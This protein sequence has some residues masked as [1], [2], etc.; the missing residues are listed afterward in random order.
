[1]KTGLFRQAFGAAMAVLTG[2]FV[3]DAAAA[4]VSF[5]GATKGSWFEP[6]NWSGGAVPTAADD[7]TIS[8]KEVVAEGDI[9]AGSISLASGANLKLGSKDLRPN[10]TATI[11][12]DFT[13]D[14]A[15]KVYVYAGELADPS[16]FYTA[17]Q[18]DAQ[19][20]AAIAALWQYRNKVIVGG[21][22]E[23]K[24]N[25]TVYPDSP[26][27]TAVPVVFECG[28]FE[29]AE[30][31]SF[32]SRGR[33]FD[34]I[35][36]L[37]SDA[38][39]GAK[40][41][42]MNSN[43]TFSDYGWTWAFGAGCG[44]NTG[45]GYG[46][47]S[48]SKKS[49]TKSG[50]T[51]TYGYAY[52]NS[53]APFLSG[54]PCGLYQVINRPDYWASNPDSAR[55]SG[56]IVIYSTGAMT[57]N[58]EMNAS[59]RIDTYVIGNGS[60]YAAA[61]GG[62]IWLVTAESAITFGANALL[63]ARGGKSSN[64][65]SY[66]S[67]GPG[68]R[69]AVAVNV[70]KAQMD[71]LAAG[72]LPAGYLESSLIGGVTA[73]VSSHGG[74][75]DYVGTLSYVSNKKPIPVHVTG[76]GSVRCGDTV[77]T[78]D[79]TVDLAI[80][81]TVTLEA[82]DTAYGAFVYWVTNGVNDVS[83]TI[84]VG[85]GLDEV[86]AGFRSSRAV[87]RTWNGSVSTAWENP[88]N[89]TPSGIPGPNDDLIVSGVTS[90]TMEILTGSFRAHDLVVGANATVK[91]GSKADRTV[92]IA[93]EL[94]GDFVVTNGGKFYAYGP[95]LVDVS[96]YETAESDYYATL[97]PALWTAAK[98]L[99]IGGDFT[100]A[101]NSS[102]YVDTDSVTGLPQI[103]LVGGDFTVAEGGLVS[104]KDRGWS[105]VV[106]PT[107]EAIA[108]YK[109]SRTNGAWHN[110]FLWTLAPGA[111]DDYY[112]GAGYGGHG[113]L[114]SSPDA[115]R[116]E[117]GHYYSNPYGYAF[118]PF[119]AGSPSGI[120]SSGYASWTDAEKTR[121]GGQVTVFAKGTAAIAGRVDA[122]TDHY[123]FAGASGGGIWIA[124]D[125][126][127]F[128]DTA[129][130]DVHGGDTYNVGSYKAGSGG[131][132]AFTECTNDVQLATMAG[133]ALP[134]G[135]LDLGTVEG[136]VV[137]LACGIQHTKGGDHN[138]D[139]S[140][141]GTLAY[142]KE[143][144]AVLHVAIDGG[145]SIACGGDV[146]TTNFTLR[147]LAGTQIVLTATADPGRFNNWD[148][149]ILAE[150]NRYSASLTLDNFR[151]PEATITAVMP[152]GHFR[153]VWTGAA[154]DGDLA[155]KAN[156][157]PS[158][159]EIGES[160]DLVFSNR[161]VTLSKAF[162]AGG[163]ILEGSS[164]LT[165]SPVA[166]EGECTPAALYAGATAIRLPYGLYLRGTSKLVVNCDPVTGTA[167]KFEV[168]DFELAKGAKIDAKAKGWYWFE[169]TDDPRARFTVAA[170]NRQ[171]IALGAGYDYYIGGG[172]GANGGGANATY[173]L[174]YGFAAA[175]FL[176][177]SPNGMYN[178]KFD[179]AKRGGGV[180][181]IHCTGTARVDGTIDAD[182]ENV[183][184]GVTSYGTA[185][186]GSIWITAANYIGGYG[187]VLR[188]QSGDVPTQSYTSLG[189]GGR[190]AIGVG[191]TAAEIDA[192]AAGSEVSD[193]TVTD[194]IYSSDVSVMTGYS[195]HNAAS[196]EFY[197]GTPGTAVTVAG[198]S[199]TVLAV[200]SDGVKATGV[201]PM[202]GVYSYDGALPAFEA[203]EYGYDPGNPAIR[204]VSAGYELSDSAPYTLVWKWGQKQY[205][206]KVNGETTWVD[207]DAEHTVSFTP[208]A[209][210]EFIVWRGTLPKDCSDLATFTA[211][212]VAPIEIEAVTKPQS[213]G[214]TYTWSGVG[215]WY[216][217]SMWSPNGIPG[218]NDDVVIDGGT[219]TVTA[220]VRCKSLTLS[221]G[222]VNVGYENWL[223]NA[224]LTVVG[225]LEVP[226]GKLIVYGG[227][228]S[229]FGSLADGGAWVKVGG[230]LT[231]SGTS[232]VW[233]YSQYH[234]G[235]SPV[236]TAAS[237]SVASTAKFDAT[238][239]G[240]QWRDA[241]D[242]PVENGYGWHYGRGGGYG[243]RGGASGTANQYWGYAY[244][245][246]FAPIHP[247]SPNGVYNDGYDHIKRGGGLVRIHVTGT[248]TV[249]GK[250]LAE[251]EGQASGNVFGGASGGGIWITANAFAFGSGA[252]LSVKG[253]PATYASVGGGGRIAL[254]YNQRPEN[255]AALAETGF[256]FGHRRMFPS[257]VKN[258]AEF[259]EL[260]P[261]VTVNV[262]SGDQHNTSGAKTG[263]PYSDSA[264]TFAYVDCGSLPGGTMFLIR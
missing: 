29:L 86:S 15:S 85:S 149:D 147:V 19:R 43:T 148:G 115:R 171:T 208:A 53:F 183:A 236:F 155:N 66:G 250:I 67:D 78:E 5:T 35:N 71:T 193:V 34:Y 188:A 204:Y 23:V 249:D 264:G 84:T 60:E 27:K 122:S 143:Q 69:I 76:D 153:R 22:L 259:A 133:G 134:L 202:Y 219:C 138:P 215:N 11:T 91:L 128:G 108:G 55:G 72:S 48:S 261:G 62:S 136:A 216:E 170:V 87:V 194:G 228:A 98:R 120:T 210:D 172:H 117:G 209:G 118:A 205:R 252:E 12:G 24:G 245:Q 248:A 81:E 113:Y 157:N 9:V 191:L 167:P 6:T 93:F 213:A 40:P 114:A 129:V 218:A 96:V 162:T 36:E 52:G 7:V 59:S 107:S 260:F 154:G 221:A 64:Y 175:P 2:V 169:G 159:F 46:A 212:V 144:E 166:I 263:G 206:V 92:D 237:L 150:G 224:T 186:G 156:Y 102:V 200:E 223:T 77:Y 152:T 105:W 30:G 168:G 178:K 119:L 254:G 161:S 109:T 132:V 56:A 101:T 185:S 241:H 14:G 160:D 176:P 174:A 240:M 243:G 42:S 179:N 207:A 111:G 82:V 231:L 4:D 257:C 139:L 187:S 47:S 141:S 255:I 90:T 164:T 220:N 137:N 192:L 126:F 100:V 230:A 196:G 10:I 130:F 83:A 189:A 37:Y 88:S 8:G 234:D 61:T 181:R 229:G 140:E 38:P 195:L 251:G 18:G 103:F 63:R 244:G 20:D 110:N 106:G 238:A 21:R 17:Y 226:N 32:N 180:V 54:S 70:S 227:P 197:H 75:L 97:I 58:G 94:S 201:E 41:N 145:G 26:K 173:G 239:K 232:E 73:D 256:L 3:N 13:V 68:G 25:S 89:W 258:A 116:Y 45:A 222:R 217:A 203:P 121:G 235:G 39:A 104:A 233:P 142:V 262:E 112:T 198:S 199:K 1:M 246:E 225:D 151:A 242:H 28:S 182:A 184:T 74:R 57:V 124:A 190:V 247:G 33:G 163:I 44:F 135:Y 127:E 80:G 131:R 95:A 125:T 214:V 253:G 123:D 79:F 211:K 49:L 50:V 31:S 158:D 165:V 16:P 177:G 51:Y 65:A 99:A 146:Y